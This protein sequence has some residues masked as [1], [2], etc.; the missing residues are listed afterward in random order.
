MMQIPESNLVKTEEVIDAS[1]EEVA[2]S[3]ELMQ[4]V[5]DGNVENVGRLLKDG[6]NHR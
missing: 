4:A 6:A 3:Q 1:Q 5:A 2:K